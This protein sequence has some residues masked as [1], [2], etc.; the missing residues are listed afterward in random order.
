M[1]DNA[2][3]V[4]PEI[5]LHVMPRAD[6]GPTARWHVFQISEES[7]RIT[8]AGSVTSFVEA[9]DLATRDHASLRFAPVAWAEMVSAGVAPEQIPEAITV[10]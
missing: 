2:Q 8:L 4:R 5:Y 7:P 3:T 1:A 9:R 6:N 10:E